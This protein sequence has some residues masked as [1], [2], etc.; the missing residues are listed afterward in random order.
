MHLI[1]CHSAVV[2]FPHIFWI[3]FALINEIRYLQKNMEKCVELP[4]F[5]MIG[6]NI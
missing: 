6:Q 5:F 1:D 3:V 2:V 4:F